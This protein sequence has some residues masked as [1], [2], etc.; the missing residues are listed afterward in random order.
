MG[1]AGILVTRVIGKAVR[2]NTKWY[3]IDD[4]VYGAFSG[5]VY[6]KMSYQFF[7]LKENEKST[8]CIVAGPTCDSFD[9]VTTRAVLPELEVGDVLVSPNMGA[10]T[11]VSATNFNLYDK[12]QVVLC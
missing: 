10:Y 6:D 8:Q 2:N 1:P 9:V 7:S 12:P 3:Y 11:T 4:G 5:Q